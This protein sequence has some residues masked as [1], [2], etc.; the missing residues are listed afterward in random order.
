MGSFKMKTKLTCFIVPALLAVSA[1]EAREYHV[2]PTGNDNSAGSSAQPLKTISAAAA[3]AQPGDVITIHAGTYRETIAPPRGGS[4]EQRIIYQAA[5]NEEVIIKGS[6]RITHWKRV[7]GDTW[8]AIIPNDFFGQFNPY[9]DVIKGDWFNDRGRDHHTGSVYLNNHWLVEAESLEELEQPTSD[10]PLWFAQVSDTETTIWAQFK[11]I[12]PNEEL[13]EINTRQALFYPEK[14]GMNFITVSG[15]TLM[16]AATPWA[17]PTAEQIG[18]IGTHWSKGWVIENNT[19]SYSR[20]TCITL[21]KYGDKWDNTSADTADG[22]V[23]TIERAG[24]NGWSDVGFHVIRGNKISH[25]GQAGIVGSLGATFSEVSDNEIHDIH[26][27]EDFTGAEIA[28]IKFHAPIN[29]LIKN[30]HIYNSFRGIWLD[31]MTQGAR[32]TGNFLHDNAGSQDLF[33][34]VNHGPFLVDHNIV[35]SANAED[36]NWLVKYFHGNYMPWNL[37]R[38]VLDMSQGGTY[39]H[40]LFMGGIMLRDELER[41]TPFMAPNS[42]Q[43]IGLKPIKGGDSHYYNNVLIN[44]GVDHYGDDSVPTSFN[45]NVYLGEA[46]PYSLDKN[47]HVAADITPEINVVEKEDGWYLNINADKSWAGA[48]QR[49]LVT[50]EMLGKTRVTGE[51]YKTPKGLNFR[52]DHDYLGASRN[53]DNPFPGPFSQN[54]LKSKLIK[55]WSKNAE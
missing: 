15:L 6:E 7:S 33:L 49:S 40:N 2:S 3:F 45:G 26:V 16:H 14:P 18:L 23:N 36:P 42:T 41:D 8:Q 47:A 46:E 39:A 31:W 55:V 38:S 20:S 4:S 32:V 34:E 48:I 22:Y 19:I 35:V 43:V 25:C 1:V 53:T 21:G 13:V 10:E 44:R 50:T 51:T 24:K 28:A 29:S 11:D 30:N 27:R 37:Q 12:N 52:L 17:P 9:N 54:S 5:A